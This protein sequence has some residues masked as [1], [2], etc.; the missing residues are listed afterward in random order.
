MSA[1]TNESQRNLDALVKKLNEIMGVS[2]AGER[3]KQPRRSLRYECDAH[4][5]YGPDLRFCMVEG[6]VRNLT[7][8]GLSVIS[9]LTEPILVGRPVEVRV[10]SLG[11]PLTSLAGTVVFCR[12][13]VGECHEIGILVQASSSDPILTH[14]AEAARESYAWFAEALEVGEDSTVVS[15]SPQP[16][17]EP[18]GH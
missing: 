12:P 11:G 17:V 4:L 6:M 15:Q 10:P 2:V 5:F 7:F 14:D 1:D 16:R 9:G 13:V 3:R 8:D 18:S